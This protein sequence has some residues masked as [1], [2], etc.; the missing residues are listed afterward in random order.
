MPVLEKAGSGK[1]RT[2]DLRAGKVYPRATQVKMG[3]ADSSAGGDVEFWRHCTI[4]TF[5]QLHYDASQRH[6]LA[7]TW[8]GLGWQGVEGVLHAAGNGIRVSGHASFVV[9]VGNRRWMVIFGGRFRVGRRF[10]RLTASRGARH[11]AQGAS[12]AQLPHSID[13]IH[14]PQ[15]QPSAQPFR[16]PRP[17]EGSHRGG[18]RKQL[19]LYEP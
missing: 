18:I 1:R 7:W 14:R 6:P 12:T 15:A 10:Q 16:V 3:L 5:R 19:C 2:V 11:S 8:L 4:P 9:V 17:K 13:P